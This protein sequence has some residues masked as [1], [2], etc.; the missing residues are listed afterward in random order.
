MRDSAIMGPNQRRDVL[1][2]TT[3]GSENETLD[4]LLH[5]DANSFNHKNGKYCR[6]FSGVKYKPAAS[7]TRG[8]AAENKVDLS[9]VLFA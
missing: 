9:A 6:P 1:R 4:S 2:T 8:R 3:R 7:I 5:G